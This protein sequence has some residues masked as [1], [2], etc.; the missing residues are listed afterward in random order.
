MNKD[1]FNLDFNEN[2]EIAGT[3]I[4]ITANDLANAATL[5]HKLFSI[6]YYMVKYQASFVIKAIDISEGDVV[7]AGNLM[8]LFNLNKIVSLTS[9]GDWGALTL[10]NA[11][12]YNTWQQNWNGGENPIW[13]M[14]NSFIPFY[15]FLDNIL[16]LDNNRLEELFSSNFGVVIEHLTIRGTA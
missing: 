15:L 7:I 1:K 14:L 16:T 5:R 3:N 4:I 12:N 6:V 8:E 10:T 9:D 2:P 13:T 11:E